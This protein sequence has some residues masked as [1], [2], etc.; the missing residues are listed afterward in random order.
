M[1]QSKRFSGIYAPIATVFTPENVIDWQAMEENISFYNKTSLAGLVV[2]GSNGEFALLSHQEKVELISFTREKLSAEKHL[3]AGT[4][5]ESAIE[6]IELS[7]EAAAAGAEAALVITPWYYKGSYTEAV[8]AKHFETIA[9]ALPIPLMLYN[10]PRNTGINITAQ[11]A[12]KLSGHDNIVGV[13]D[14]GGDIV[15]ISNI[16]GNTPDDFAVFAGSGSFLMATILAGGS[17]GTLAIA[18]VMPEQCVELFN[19]CNEGKIEEARRLQQTLMQPNAAVTSGF[20]IPGLKKALELIGLY[21]GAP[22]LP[23]LP[24]DEAGSTKLAQILRDAGVKIKE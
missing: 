21:G 4:G 1:P 10:M 13:K 11:L 18:N 8:L 5:C 23:L 3:I 15:Q 2:L 17:G 12:I 7:K 24:L 20:G 16:I 14:S 6:T 9:D 22:R 19:L